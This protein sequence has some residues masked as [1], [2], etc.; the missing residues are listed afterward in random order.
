MRRKK[1]ISVILAAMLLSVIVVAQSFKKAAKSRH[2]DAT[3]RNGPTKCAT[4][5]GN[6]IPPH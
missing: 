1:I 3:W 4:G 2:M 6:R 5:L